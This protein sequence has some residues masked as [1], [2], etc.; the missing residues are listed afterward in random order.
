MFAQIY[1]KLRKGRIMIMIMM[2]STNNLAIAIALALFCKLV[3]MES[4]VND[5]CMAGHGRAMSG[6]YTYLPGPLFVLVYYWE[7]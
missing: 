2:M 5:I 4:P 7:W 1:R 6:T 3:T